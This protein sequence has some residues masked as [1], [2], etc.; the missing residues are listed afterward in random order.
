M[1]NLGLSRVEEAV[2]ARH[3]GL[4]EYAACQSH[5]FLKGI[6]AF[7]TGFGAA[8]AL[9]K[10]L[11]RKLPYP[12]QWTVLLAVVA[13]SAGSYAVTRAETRKCSDLWLFLETGRLPQDGAAEPSI[14]LDSPESREPAPRRNRY[15]DVL[16]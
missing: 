11:N 13:G 7:I 14:R 3:P 12:M 16:E 2:A 6:G 4:Q 1:V 5:A 15:G 10:L 9:Q 8:F